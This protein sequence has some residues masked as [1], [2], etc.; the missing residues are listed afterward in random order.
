MRNTA[1]EV[2]AETIENVFAEFFATEAGNFGSREELYEALGERLRGMSFGQFELHLMN[3]INSSS[4]I[5]DV[6]D[7][8]DPEVSAAETYT[9]DQKYQYTQKK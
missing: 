7:I 1:T 9:T 4:D 8:S 6:R 2:Q 5:I 3:Y